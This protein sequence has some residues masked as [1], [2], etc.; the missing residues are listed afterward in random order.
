MAV[1]PEHIFPQ[2]PDP[3]WK[4]ELGEA[5][6]DSIKETYLNTIANLTLSGNNGRLG[7]K[8]FTEKRDMNEGEKEQG[9]RFS[10]L[11][12][13]KGLAELQRWDC[14]AIEARFERIAHRF[15]H[16]WK[17]PDVPLKEPASE[18]VNIFDADDPTFRKLEYAVFF[19]QKLDFRQVSKLYDHVLKTLFEAEPDVFFSPEVSA[20][21]SLTQ[22]P[23]RLRQSSKISDTFYVEANMDSRNK[24]E[25]IKLLLSL[26]E[27]EDELFVKYE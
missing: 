14:Q 2:N 22:D 18:E 6:Y 26:L 27:L 3:K 17:Y 8:Y 21:L 9:Y 1:T 12:L 11:W 24:F 20:K 10:R 19:D 16:I 13:N 25:R 15:L 4:M 7:N 5:E 23:A